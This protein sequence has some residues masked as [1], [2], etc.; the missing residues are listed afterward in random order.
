[1]DNGNKPTSIFDDYSDVKEC[2]DCQH[3]WDNSCDGSKGAT[4]PC[5]AFL[6]T[7]RV[8]LPEDVKRLTKRVDLLSGAII[9]VVLVQIALLHWR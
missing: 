2:T 4:R 9:L 1:M 5:K 3:W 7:R 8:T 6:A